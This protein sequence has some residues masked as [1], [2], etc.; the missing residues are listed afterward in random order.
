MKKATSSTIG[1]ASK[2]KAIM[3]MK[4]QLLKKSKSIH[5]ISTLLAQ[6]RLYAAEPTSSL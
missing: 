6:F 3:P 5:F 4:V 2:H 1:K